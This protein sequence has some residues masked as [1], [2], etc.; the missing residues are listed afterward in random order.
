[1][2]NTLLRRTITD[3]VDDNYVYAHVLYYFGIRFYEY[4][5]DTLEQ[6]CRR[7]GL[8]ATQLIRSLENALNTPQNTAP[9]LEALPVDLVV[10]YLRHAHAVFIKRT[11]PYMAHLVE[12]LRPETAACVK[13]LQLLF[14]LFVEDFI[15]H[16]HEEEDTFFR[17]VQLLQQARN[18][19]VPTGK[20][21]FELEKHSV[22][23]F[24]MDHETHDDE[25]AGIR[26]IT[27]QYTLPAGCSQ[28]LKVVFAELKAFET[29]L[30]THARVENEIL[31]PKAL[32]L[33]KEVKDL[34]RHSAQWN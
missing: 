29:D 6:V 4:A 21:F 1:M 28:H 2:Q 11:L 13:D 22:Q 18:R 12:T 3:L 32:V 31:F 7:R 33:E 8:D 20:V 30:I 26:E 27:N 15:I 23:H 19:K 24:A 25:M 17:H 16:I 14:P 5:D 34:L 9:V 10:E